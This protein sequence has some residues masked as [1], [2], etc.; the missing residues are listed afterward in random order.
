M[1]DVESKG[2]CWRRRLTVMHCAHWRRAGWA[3]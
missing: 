3:G 1:H 2:S